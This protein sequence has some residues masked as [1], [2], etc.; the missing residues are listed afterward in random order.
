MKSA[1]WPRRR[2][3]AR[4][5]GRTWPPRPPRWKHASSRP[6]RG[7]SEWTAALENL[8]QQREAANAALT[9]TKV[10][11]ATGGAIVRLVRNQK[12][13]LEQRLAELGHLVEQRRREIQ[14]FI[15]RNGQAEAEIA[16]SRQ[17][18]RR[19]GAQT[20]AG[21][22]ADRRIAGAKTGGGRGDRAGGRGACAGSGDC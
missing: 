16:E 21:Q 13:P 17:K 4:A 14:S 19:A 11:L 2:R 18:M 7:L 1:A 12:R 3:K 8:R 9:E 6:R 20:R 22:R 10:A 5:E 15:E